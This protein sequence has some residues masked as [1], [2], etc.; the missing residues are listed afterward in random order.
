MLRISPPAMRRIRQ[1]TLAALAL[2]FVFVLGLTQ[3]AYADVIT[4]NSGVRGRGDWTWGTYELK[5]VYLG[6]R[7]L[8]CDGNSV[9]VHLRVYTAA[10]SSPFD[11]THR[12]N[13]N[14]CGTARDWHNLGVTANF[15]ITGVRVRACVDHGWPTGDN[16]VVS[17][18]HDNPL[19]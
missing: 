2:T 16:C 10:G 7:D 14:G 19:T 4:E 6:V 17:E 9:Y 15:R 18:Y 3:N 11:T 13:H 5:N 8:A 1:R 12:E